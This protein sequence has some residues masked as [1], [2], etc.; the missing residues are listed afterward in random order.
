MNNDPIVIEKIYNASIDRVWK[1]ITDKDQIKQ[2]FAEMVGFRPEVGAEFHFDGK[3]AGV[4]YDHSCKVLEVTPNK[5]L[6]YS[7][8]KGGEGNTLVSF[9]LVAEGNKT[10]LKLTHSGFETFP[11]DK[12]AF[13]RSNFF[14]GW[15]A[16]I[17]K[18]LMELV[19][20]DSNSYKVSMS[21]N[22]SPREAFDGISRVSEWWTNDLDGS[23]RE[24]ND[25]FT[26]HHNNGKTFVTMK[27]TEV[28]PDKMIV[29]EVT[30]CYLDWLEDKTEWKNT[31]LIWNISTASNST[32]I[33][34][35]HAGLVPE[36]ECYND[37]RK[38]WDFYIKESLY[39]LLTQHKGLPD[40]KTNS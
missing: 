34:M 37:C 7:F 24:L 3:D 12:P 21:S 8:S 28:I 26:T 30:D 29:W 11:Q 15:T 5:K 19:E 38:G 25:E 39:K 14:G 1:A 18:R 40:K 36:I 16:L 27:L 32:T 35:T 13:A 23:S 22:V 9:E 4:V 17:G 33:H 2:W 6:S 20:A 10:K 31:R